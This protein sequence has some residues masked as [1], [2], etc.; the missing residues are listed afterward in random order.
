MEDITTTRINH[1]DKTT[2]QM[3]QAGYFSGYERCTPCFAGVSYG[4]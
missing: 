1:G 2:I 3:R 4:I